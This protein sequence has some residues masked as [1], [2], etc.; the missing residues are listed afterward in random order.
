MIGFWNQQHSKHATIFPPSS[1]LADARN[2]SRNVKVSRLITSWVHACL[3]F[4]HIMGRKV[5]SNGHDCEAKLFDDEGRF[6]SS[7]PSSSSEVND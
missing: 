5:R 6:R 2:V 4:L 3:E 1:V 7:I